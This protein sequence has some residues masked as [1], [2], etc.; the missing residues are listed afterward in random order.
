MYLSWTKSL[1]G[2]CPQTRYQILASETELVAVGKGGVTGIVVDGW[3]AVAG[4]TFDRLD[5]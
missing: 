2:H 5:G 4:C 1:L 3:L